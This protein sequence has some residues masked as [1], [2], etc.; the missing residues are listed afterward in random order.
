M[1]A[2]PVRRKVDAL[3]ALAGGKSQR[4]VAEEVG[5]NPATIRAW[6]RDPVF[7]AELV[8]MKEVVVQ[9]PLIPEAVFAAMDEAAGRLAPGGSAAGV[10]TV[11]IPAGASPRRRRQLVARAVARVLE[12]SEGDGR[13]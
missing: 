8:R 12:A 2:T 6:N 9:R 10:V 4:K 5:V 7:A 13:G 3:L 11:R 1:S